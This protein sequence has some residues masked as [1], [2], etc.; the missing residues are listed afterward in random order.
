ML[1]Q[2]LVVIDVF[3]LV[4]GMPSIV[5]ARLR[6][7]Y[8]IFGD[9]T[10]MLSFIARGWLHCFDDFILFPL[11]YMF[12]NLV[13]AFIIACISGGSSFHYVFHSRFG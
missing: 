1:G 8:L 5:L 7:Q 2:S 10:S 4:V 13:A 11:P 9:M 3:F 12:S 6:F